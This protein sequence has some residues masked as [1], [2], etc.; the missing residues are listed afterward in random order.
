MWGP[1]ITVPCTSVLIFIFLGKR[2]F[3]RNTI[4]IQ[5]NYRGWHLGTLTVC[6]WALE[7]DLD[8]C[9]MTFGTGS[10]QGHWARI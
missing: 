10:G 2:I 8:L 7:L 9:A 3:A 5:R 6:D 1:H 4:L